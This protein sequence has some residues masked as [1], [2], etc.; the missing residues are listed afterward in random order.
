MV[1][2]LAC[3]KVYP[4]EKNPTCPCSTPRQ[5]GPPLYQLEGDEVRP[6]GHHFSMVVDEEGVGFGGGEGD[7]DVV[8]GRVQGVEGDVRVLVHAVRRELEKW[9]Q[10]AFEKKFEKLKIF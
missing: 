7:A 2:Q 5:S 6:S 1:G 9:S 3:Q 10:E 4:Y 8:G